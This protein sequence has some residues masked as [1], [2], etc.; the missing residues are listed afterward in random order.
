MQDGAKASI[1]MH[2]TF[3]VS[4]QRTAPPANDGG[5]YGL[6]LTKAEAIGHANENATEAAP[7]VRLGSRPRKPIRVATTSYIKGV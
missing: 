2:A 1:E 5:P 7:L 6:M 4:Q 3:I